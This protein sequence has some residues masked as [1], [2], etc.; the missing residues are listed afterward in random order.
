MQL[1]CFFSLPLLDPGFPDLGG[2]L[3]GWAVCRW[4]DLC[5]GRYN[6]RAVWLWEE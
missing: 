1:C 6:H 3:L 2:R 4:S 5:D